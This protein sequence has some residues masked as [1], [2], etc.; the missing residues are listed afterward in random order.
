MLDIAPSI[1]SADFARLGEELKALDAAGCRIVHLDVMDGLF[2]PNI[3]FGAP[4]IKS[5]R[6][7]TDMVFDAHLMI[8]EPARFFDDFV[9][10]G[11]DG[12]TIHYEAT[13]NAPADLKALR[14]LGVRAGISI[15][16]QTRVEQ[17]EHLLALCDLVLVMSVEPGFGGQ[18]FQPQALQKLESLASLREQK[19]YAYVL[20]VDGGVNRE[21]IPAV[22]SAGA[23]WLV[24]GSAFFKERDYGRALFEFQTLANK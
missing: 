15:K 21:T 13:V 2:V 23:D 9:K 3:T 10:A 8:D 17:I 18:S 16:P 19:G 24:M 11:A 1:L 4:V 12:I 14:Q 7:Y 22:V 6:P 20:E 5:L